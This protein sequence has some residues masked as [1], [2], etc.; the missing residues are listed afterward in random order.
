MVAIYHGVIY[1]TLHK[2]NLCCTVYRRSA[3]SGS[4]YDAA[5]IAIS[6]MLNI[7]EQNC[8]GEVNDVYTLCTH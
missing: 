8:K 5:S 1:C 4:Q 3:A 7:F 2:Y 6:C